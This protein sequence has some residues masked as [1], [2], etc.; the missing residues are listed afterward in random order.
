V[1]SYAQGTSALLLAQ[2]REYAPDGP[3]VNVTGVIIT[4]TALSDGSVAV[5]PTAVGVSNPAVGNNAYTWAI[6]ASQATGSYIVVWNGT[7]PD[8]SSVQASEVISVTAVATEGSPPGLCEPWPVIWSCPLET[9]ATAVSGTALQVA[10]EVL[11]GMSGRQFGVCTLTVRPCRRDCFDS[12][13]WAVNPWSTYGGY[14]MPVLHAGQW[15]NITCGSCQGECSCATLSEVM[16]PGPV[17]EVTEVKVDGVPLVKNVDYRVDDWRILV[18]LGG[19]EWPLCNN[20]NLADTEVGTWSVTMRVGVEVPPLGRVAVGVLAEQFIKALL[21]D[22]SCELPA[23]VQSLSRQGINVTFLDPN[24][25]FE[26]GQTGLYFPDL[27]IRTVNPN[28][29]TRRARVYDLDNRAVRR[30]LGTS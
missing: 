20:L 3:F 22:A 12:A 4:I 28:R 5:G 6:P 23:T 30:Q 11:W 14:P 27:F 29:L 7:A 2:W 8:L 17:V 15:F 25:V 13:W 18:R 26:N 10:S 24:A 19:A 1:T 9:T 21:C 16:L